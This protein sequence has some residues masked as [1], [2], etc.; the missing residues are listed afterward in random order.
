[1]MN[2]CG[3]REGGSSVCA[4]LNDVGPRDHYMLDRILLPSG[5]NDTCLT[6]TLSTTPQCHPDVVFES[7]NMSHGIQE[8]PTRTHSE[9]KATAALAVV[10][11]QIV[12][13]TCETL[14]HHVD[15]F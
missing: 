10:N 2:N 5:L 9:L 8:P 6:Q 12:K 13:W 3:L 7:R 11:K 14:A 15:L 4:Y 1:M